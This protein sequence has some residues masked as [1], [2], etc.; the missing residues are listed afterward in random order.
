MVRKHSLF[1]STQLVCTFLILTAMSC[2][3]SA[4]VKVP[5]TAFGSTGAGV[6]D[7]Y[8]QQLLIRT[9]GV[10]V[11][12]DTPLGMTCMSNQTGGGRFFP[13]IFSSD[14]Q[15]QATLDTLRSAKLWYRPIRIYSDGCYLGNPSDSQFQWPYISALD[16]R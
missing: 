10:H 15:Y 1:A 8:I 2:A 7:G 11:V 3:A 4:Q 12:M 16:M 13:V 6:V 14:P 5:G 9:Y